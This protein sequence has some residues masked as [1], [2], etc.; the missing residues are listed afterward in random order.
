M[1]FFISIGSVYA[2]PDKPSIPSDEIRTFVSVYRVL[3]DSSVER[4]DGKRLIIA[5]IRGMAKDIDPDGGE[6]FTEEEFDAYKK[7]NPPGWGSVGMD[8]RTRHGE[9]ILAPISG[10]PA[11]AAGLRFGD[12][13]LSVDGKSVLTLHSRPILKTLGGP[14]GTKVMIGVSREGAQL[15]E[16]PVERKRFDSQASIMSR[17]DPEIAMLALSRLRG[18]ELEEAVS[19][20]QREW[21]ARP[22]KSLIVDLRG[23]GGGLLI[24]SIGI[25]SIFLP[26][27]ALIA[28]TTGKSPEANQVYRAN[29]GAYARGAFGDP[30]EGIP[31]ELKAIPLVVLIDDATA[32]GAEIVAAALKDHKRATLIGKKTFGS[33]SIQTFTPIPGAGA[34]KYTSAYWMTPSGNPIHDIGVSPQIDVRDS[35][36]N[37]AVA[38]AISWLKARN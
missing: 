16:L 5:A 32:S 28:T 23:N 12:R 25:A 26:A 27:D 31:P 6:Y 10:G 36:P 30:L 35:D 21:N 7:G 1:C 9:L 37:R 38:E 17:P 29:K 14:T 34:I 4:T 15:V 33:G 24:T 11:E 22:F 20:L 2:E 13:L 8:I 19:L 18:N 3:L